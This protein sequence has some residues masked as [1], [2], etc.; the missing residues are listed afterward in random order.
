MGLQ[1]SCS[2]FEQLSTVFHWIAVQYLCTV[3]MVHLINDFLIVSALHKEGQDHP[4]Q[5]QLL[6][7]DTGIRLLSEKTFTLSTTMNLLGYEIDSMDMEVRLPLDKLQ[8]CWDYI[9][10]CC[11]R[12]KLTL[13]NI[14]NTWNTEFC[15]CQHNAWSGIL[16]RLIDFTTVEQSDHIYCYL[17]NKKC[18]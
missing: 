3:H 6:C 14:V 9:Q 5:V 7:R 17:S 1:S 12:P 11:Q 18:T 16:S 2:I 15:L 4:E 13:K 8:K 10:T